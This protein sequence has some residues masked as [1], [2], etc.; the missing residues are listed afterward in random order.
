VVFAVVVSL[1]AATARAA[2]GEPKPLPDQIEIVDEPRP[3]GETF[4][5]QSP[6]PAEELLVVDMQGLDPWAIAAL[7]CLQALTSRKQPC[8]WLL[9]EWDPWDEKDLELHVRKGYIK[10]YRQVE[11]WALTGWSYKQGA[12]KGV[13]EDLRQD[14]GDRRPAFVNA[15]LLKWEYGW[16][17]IQQIYDLRGPDAVFVTPTQLAELYRQYHR[18]ARS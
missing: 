4:F 2:E 11:D 6:P 1:P 14:I 17:E 3:W 16:D 7:Q 5:P 10:G 9:Y 18:E 12:A 13:W 15:F 8:L